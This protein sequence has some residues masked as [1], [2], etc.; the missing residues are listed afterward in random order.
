MLGVVVYG[1][2][3]PQPIVL[4]GPQQKVESVNPL[5]GV[6]T[7][8]TDEVEEWKIQRTLAL[9]REMGAGWVVEYFPWQYVEPAKGSYSWEHADSVIAHARR[10]GLKVIARIGYAPAW[11]RPVGSEVSYLEPARYTDLGEFVAAFAA[12]YR[13]QVDHLIIWN[14]PNLSLEW[15]FR[16]PS[17]AEYTEMLRA[18][19]ERAKE[20]NPEV[21][22]LAGALAPTLGAPDAMSDL[23]YLRGMYA[24][25]AASYFDA[26]AVHAYGWRFAPD[27]APDPDVINYRRVE[28][29]RQIMVEA[30]DAGTPVMIT[31][32]GWNDHPR[33]TKAVR[34]AQRVQY[35]LRAYDLARQEWDW[36]EAVALWAFRYPRPA[37]GYLD[38]YTFATVDFT[39]KPVYLA[40]QEYARGG[41]DAILRAE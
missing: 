25:G 28:L 26:L 36:C 34:P 29:L 13:G 5:I 3:P 39:L 6:H 20:V 31:E 17:P 19:Y 23:A 27:A 33:W 37:S 8:L 11:A 24:A 9:V 21:R 1:L 12:R 2:R 30:G 40:V 4:L 7:R 14:E 35:T 22:I 15:G 16:S 32:G 41:G 38:Y 18:T 10:Q